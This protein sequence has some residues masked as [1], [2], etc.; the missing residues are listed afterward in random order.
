[1]KGNKSDIAQARLVFSIFV[2]VRSSFELS[3][4]FLLSHILIIVIFLFMLE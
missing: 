4:I 3:I 1:M 2:I